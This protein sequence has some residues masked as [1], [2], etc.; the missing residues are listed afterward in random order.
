MKRCDKERY[1]YLVAGFDDAAE[2]TDVLFTLGYDKTSDSVNIAQIPRDT[3]L[4]FGSS[5]NKINQLYASQV[6]AGAEKYDAMAYTT[7]YFGKL[8]GVSFDGFIG[9]G[10]SAFRRIVD[11]LGGVEINVPKAMTVEIDGEELL[12]LREG[13]NHLNGAEAEKFIRYRKGYV[14]GDLERMDAQKLFLSALLKKLSSELTLPTL[15][16]LAGIVQNEAVT[17]IHLASFSSVVM[18]AVSD[19]AKARYITL[20]GEP[21]LNSKGLSFYVLNRKSA[22][23]IVKCYMFADKD[24]D[25]EKY[26]LNSDE[27]AFANIYND[28][29]FEIREYNDTSLPDLKINKRN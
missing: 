7:E 19:G 21:A 13:I 18:D 20:P 1:L 3:F 4:N 2:N 8:F 5:Q 9:L 24:F 27:Q 6:C 26:F 28:D 23:E 17:N 11:A 14:M 16:K 29:D 10:T 12:A 25:P 22:A 15:M